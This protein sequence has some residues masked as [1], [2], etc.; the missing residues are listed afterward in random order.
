[1][2]LTY[3]DL[4]SDGVLLFAAFFGA[5]VFAL[6]IGVTFHEFSHAIVA[7]RL[8]DR[9]ARSMGRISLHPRDHLD[10]A[11]S[12]FL[13]LAGFGWGKPVPV[14]PSRLRHGPQT[15]RAMVAAA[16]PLS[17]IV[18]ASAAA[19]PIQMG[20]VDWWN[21]L[22]RPFT[23]SAW[24]VPEYAGLFLGAMVFFNLVLAVFNLLPFAP[25][26]GFSVAVGILPRDLSITVARM[27]QYGPPI[28]MI[29]LVL[30]IFTGGQLSILHSVMGP[31][32][33]GLARTIVGHDIL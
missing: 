32:I 26:D 6:V 2:L 18:L 24:G 28:L 29:L 12:L 8:G 4:L 23:I 1:M 15:G 22:T 20:V 19:M 17:N 33:N 7:D 31:L 9:T 5:A 3:L 13:L 11:G 25:L 10:P 21:P 16:G 30:P 27:E 14:N